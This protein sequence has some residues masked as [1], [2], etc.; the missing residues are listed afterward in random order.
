M[1][2]YEEN[3]FEW[4]LRQILLLESGRVDEVDY[5]SLLNL[6]LEI[7]LSEKRT[8][9]GLARIVILHLL[10]LKYQPEK[11]TRSWMSSVA[12]NRETLQT[13]IANTTLRNHLESSLPK[14][15]KIARRLAAIETGLGPQL[16]P[17]TCPFTVG[18]I[19]DDDFFA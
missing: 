6:L 4:R 15:Y 19:L 5:D 11:A 18:Q 16:F 3:E 12:A 17:E 2:L 14:I 9:E 1:G 8:V 10:K 13:L 7:G